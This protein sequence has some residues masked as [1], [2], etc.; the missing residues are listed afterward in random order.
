MAEKE[1][2]AFLIPAHIAI[3]ALSYRMGGKKI[4]ISY[5]EG[6]RT[7]GIWT[8]ASPAEAEDMALYFQ[9]LRR[10]ERYPNSIAMLYGIR[11]IRNE[12]YIT[13]KNNA[14]ILCNKDDYPEYENSTDTPILIADNRMFT[15]LDCIM[16]GSF[17]RSKIAGVIRKAK[18]KHSF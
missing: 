6:D 16:E 12:Y 5:E 9:Q 7:S 10:N 13:L 4:T 2:I 11:E 8:C 15:I 17:S 18:K 3:R 14:M 1:K